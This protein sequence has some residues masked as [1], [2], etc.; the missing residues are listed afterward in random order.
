MEP[1]LEV[2]GMSSKEFLEQLRD[3]IDEHLLDKDRLIAEERMNSMEM[4]LEYIKGTSMLLA[5]GI[6]RERKMV[7]W[8]K[9]LVENLL[10]P[11]NSEQASIDKDPRKI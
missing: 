9:Q 6:R 8:F 4:D 1:T 7:D 3:S 2:P 11:R 10:D 5:E